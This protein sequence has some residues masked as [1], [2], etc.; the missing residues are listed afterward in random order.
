MQ[1]YHPD[2]CSQTIQG[3][4]QSG[5]EI[6][7]PDTLPHFSTVCSTIPDESPV[8]ALSE[9]LKYLIVNHGQLPDTTFF[10]RVNNLSLVSLGIYDQDILVVDRSLKPDHKKIVITLLNGEFLV[11]RFIKQKESHGKFLWNTG[12]LDYPLLHLHERQGLDIWGVV[13]LVIHAL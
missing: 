7:L 10:I 5:L 8:E 3:L 13:I 12:N 9:R 4:A 2:I 1:T 11:G 6:L